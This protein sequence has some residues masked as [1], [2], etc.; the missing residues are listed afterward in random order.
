MLTPSCLQSGKRVQS[1]SETLAPFVSPGRGCGAGRTGTGG[2]DFFPGPA[3][4]QCGEVFQPG[5]LGGDVQLH[6]GLLQGEEHLWRCRDSRSSSWS[7]VERAP[8]LVWMPYYLALWL[9]QSRWSCLLTTDPFTHN[10]RSPRAHLYILQH[11]QSTGIDGSYRP[12]FLLGALCFR[13]FM[14][15]WHW[16]VQ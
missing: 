13:P 15:S 11:P 6:P 4:C 1:V 14:F 16:P 10:H 9:P 8:L 5:F 2:R 7:C 3:L 12:A